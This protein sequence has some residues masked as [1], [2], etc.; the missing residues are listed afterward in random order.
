[1]G[2]YGL[3]FFIALGAGILITLGYLYRLRRDRLTSFRIWREFAQARGFSIHGD[4]SSFPRLTG[5]LPSSGHDFEAAVEREYVGYFS[6]HDTSLEASFPAL[7][8]D[9]HLETRATADTFRRKPAESLDPDLDQTFHSP[10]P[11]T[12]PQ[13]K[14]LLDHKHALLRVA[15]NNRGLYLRD[16]KVGLYVHGIITD[17]DALI[18]RLDELDTLCEAL[19]APPSPSR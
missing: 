9:L 12:T 11:L 14:W 3:A 7:P 15:Q 16:A 17:P 1:M 13:K 5:N 4:P 6:F 8:D 19:E 2:R 10:S 18:A